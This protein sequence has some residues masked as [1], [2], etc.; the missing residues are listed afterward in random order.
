MEVGCDVMAADYSFFYRDQQVSGFGQRAIVSVDDHMSALH[1]AGIHLAC[2]G[3][4]CADQIQVRAWAKN[5][6]IEQRDLR[7]RAG[8]KHVGLA[9][10]GSG[11]GGFHRQANFLGHLLSEFTGLD[12]IGAAD[13]HTFKT[14]D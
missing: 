2:V 12:G 5:L 11:I 4:K 1:G 8:A 14:A 9:G 13:Q 6:A 7:G 10:T 3:L